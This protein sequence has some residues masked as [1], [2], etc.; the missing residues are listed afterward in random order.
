MA[1]F[2]AR[3]GI[4]HEKSRNIRSLNQFSVRTEY[5]LE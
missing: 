3:G 5:F 2:A 4:F 1:S